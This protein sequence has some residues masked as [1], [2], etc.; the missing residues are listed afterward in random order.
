MHSAEGE[1]GGLVGRKMSC[2]AAEVS[3]LRRAAWLSVSWLL[4]S[5]FGGPTS[6]YPTRSTDDGDEDG[7]P[8]PANP[9]DSD[10]GV[11]GSEP[12]RPVGS[13][14]AGTPLRPRRMRRSS[15]SMAVT[16]RS[17]VQRAT[18]VQTLGGPWSD[19]T[20]AW[21]RDST[22]ARPMAAT[23]PLHFAPVATASAVRTCGVPLRTPMCWPTWAAGQL[24]PCKVRW[25]LRESPKCAP[26]FHCCWRWPA[27]A[28]A[29]PPIPMK[30]AGVPPVSGRSRARR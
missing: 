15:A 13:M 29:A 30:I 28:W 12:P 22:G 24:V 21:Q 5:C 2:E 16:R 6:D 9:D 23:G 17:I 8:V 14:D 7:A 20:V 4:G 25:K 27:R 18:P 3:T 10:E 19:W 1:H 11:G 26:P